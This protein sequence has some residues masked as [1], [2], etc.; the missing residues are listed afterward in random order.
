MAA[1]DLREE[2]AQYLQR[3]VT[4]IGEDVEVGAFA[5]FKGKL[6]K[7]LAPDEFG[8]LHTEYHQ[9]AAHYLESLDRGDTI[10]DIVVKEVRELA[11]KLVLTAPV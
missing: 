3:F 11:A 2:Y 7:K 10:N 5:K 4:A 9:L 1:E 6:I 8:E